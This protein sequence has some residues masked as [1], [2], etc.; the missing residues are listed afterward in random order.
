MTQD[1]LHGSTDPAE[2]APSVRLSLRYCTGCGRLGA[3]QPEQQDAYCH[4]CRKMLDRLSSDGLLARLRV[5]VRRLRR[6]SRRGA[7]KETL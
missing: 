7:R 2:V 3:A 5:D 4:L 6:R 1:P